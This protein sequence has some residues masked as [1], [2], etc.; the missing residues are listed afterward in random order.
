M[1]KLFLLSLV[2]L[3]VSM[4]ACKDDLAD[5]GSSG[6]KGIKITLKAT[7][8]DGTRANVGTFVTWAA[9][10]NIKL[11][12]SVGD[13]AIFSLVAGEGSNFADFTGTITN[14][15]ATPDR[16]FFGVYPATNVCPAGSTSSYHIL[17]NYFTAGGAVIKDGIAK[18]S[19]AEQY[20]VQ[21]QVPEIQVQ[22]VTNPASLGKYIMMVAT[23]IS[24]PWEITS[25]RD[26]AMQ[27]N[28]I[29]TIMD[30][31]LNGIPSG[32]EVKRVAVKA[33]TP[34]DI[35][36]NV[37]GYCNVALPYTDPNFLKINPLTS[38]A[39]NGA[40]NLAPSYSDLLFVKT[41]NVTEGSTASIVTLPV[42]FSSSSK[43]LKIVVT[44][45]NSS[46]GVTTDLIFDK[47]AV[48]T[49]FQRGK[50]YLTTLNLS[51][52]SSTETVLFRDDFQWI[53]APIN[54]V[55][56]FDSPR[57]GTELGYGSTG[58]GWAQSD[59][60]QGWTS[61]TTSIYERS[62]GYLKLGKTSYGGEIISPALGV[63]TGLVYS[64]PAVKVRVRM[65]SYMSSG[66]T[67]DQ[68]GY[69]VTIPE[70]G[71]TLVEASGMP[72][73]FTNFNQLK[74]FEFNVTDFTPLTRIAF[75]SGLG[76]GQV[77]KQNRFFFDDFEITTTSTPLPQ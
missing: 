53:S 52:P 23:P 68:A 7:Q 61:G 19:Q 17:W 67:L 66:A 18:S 65:S 31:K 29:C 28:Q 2:A 22:D 43:D 14:T 75:T 6:S 48:S 12:S 47:N 1:K 26:V 76:L 74:T 56:F 49:N 38:L 40:M 57:F 46:T 8:G 77:N 51:S 20:T 55:N 24:V 69:N 10:D 44:V 59:K 62:A 30:F 36:F 15:A 63:K 60:D 64:Y 50:R 45:V 3:G 27:F 73:T 32:T 35:V 41:S 11:Y 4:T 39:V 70:G 21:F 54:Y 5:L 33:A 34:G 37:R 58:K 72:Y 71:G 16:T 13:S 42:D 25:S 9:G